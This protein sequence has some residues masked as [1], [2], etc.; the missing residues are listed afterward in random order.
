[1]TDSSTH[2]NAIF[3]GIAGPSRCGKST[4]AKH[5]ADHFHSPLDPIVLDHFFIRNLTIDHP[6]LGQ[7]KSYKQ[8]DCLNIK[9]FFTLL[10]Q[11]KQNPRIITQYH[12][13]GILTNENEHI[14]VIIQG[15]LLFALSDAI[16]NLVDIK[17]F[18]DS[19][20]SEC[21]IRRHRR[22]LKIPDT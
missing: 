7:I 5:L 2:Y 18:L 11:I 1:M 3:I 20:L 19:T 10:N 13:E 14:F 4:Y 22:Q 16:T 15:F 17:I 8:P 21:R 12:R 6:I 9:G